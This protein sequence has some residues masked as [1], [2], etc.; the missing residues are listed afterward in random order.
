MDKLIV[1]DIGGTHA[2][3]AV[4]VMDA[5]RPVRLDH[6]ITMPVADHATLEQAWR[7]YCHGLAPD[8]VPSNGAIA[9][10]GSVA[11]VAR[12]EILH[13]TNN[14]WSIDSA[15]IAAT[16]GL[17][18]C[19]IC[20]DFDAVGHAVAQA[21]PDDLAP[22]CGPD[23]WPKTQRP[24][25][26]WPDTGIISIIGPGTGLG[27]ASVL[28]LAG[29]G[30][31][32]MPT[33]GGHLD[34]A[35][36]DDFEDQLLVRLRKEYGRVS[37]ERIVSG[38][39]LLAIYAL[40]AEQAG[41][42]VQTHDDKALWQSALAG[43]DPLAVQAL[44]RFCCSLGAMAGD[45]AIAQGAS[46]AVIAGG[47]GARLAQHLPQSGFAERFVAKGRYKEHMAG[48]PVRLLTSDQPGLIGAAAAFAQSKR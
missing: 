8:A 7:H 38:P 30:Y 2:R 25:T 15:H 27:I 39:G 44:E 36:L 35:P 34:F 41:Q 48:L 31:H 9:M 40:L 14:P 3:F 16:L 32:V 33:E 37:I 1:A 23:H 43:S 5:G 24:E 11:G 6:I 45:I 4:A 28:R 46:A 47:L 18:H 19:L 42:P 21:G 22:L 17:D 13:F 20:N 10:A 29:G 26:E 12:G